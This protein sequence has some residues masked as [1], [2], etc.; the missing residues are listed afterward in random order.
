MAGGYYDRASKEQIDANNRIHHHPSTSLNVR[1]LLHQ[2]R[3]GGSEEGTVAD[4]EMIPR[5]SE[6]QLRPKREKRQKR[7][8]RRARVPRAP[9][10]SPSLNMR[11][12]L[13]QL[14]DVSVEAK[15]NAAITLD[16]PERRLRPKRGKGQKRRNRRVRVPRAPTASPSL[17]MRRVLRDLSTG[18]GTSDNSRLNE[19]WLGHATSTTERTK[20]VKASLVVTYCNGD[21]DWLQKYTDGFIFDR[22]FVAIKCGILPDRDV[23]PEGAELVPLP[24][25]GGCD[26]TMAYW[27][28]EVLPTLPRAHDN[29]DDGGDDDE[30]SGDEVVLFLKDDMR[31]RDDSMNARDFRTLLDLALSDQGFGCVLEPSPVY[32]FSYYHE[33]NV[34]QGFEMSG[35]T[36]ASADGAHDGRDGAFYNSHD[37]SDTPF[38][39]TYATLGDWHSALHIDLPHPLVPV[40]YGGMFM[41]KRTKIEEV[42][43]EILGNLTLSLSRGN[44]IEEG[45][46]AERTWAGLFSE[47]LA[48]KEAQTL[49]ERSRMIYPFHD[50]WTGS[51]M[52]YAVQLPVHG[53]DEDSI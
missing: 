6:R 22:T 35:Y 7:Q 40:C 31:S 43:V 28:A 47:T 45:H 16:Q 20:T 51:L 3:D 53:A 12:V 19:L 36:R 11:R 34:L 14:N 44:N 52:R 1:S 48:I 50:S 30:D 9:T 32:G 10:P 18:D 49:L 37:D 23:L 25:V 39:S 8:K 26:H 33:I 5:T 42:P 17:N 29:D 38:K 2:L 46:F 15:V 4:A 21:L 24:N 41:V 13:R 27:M